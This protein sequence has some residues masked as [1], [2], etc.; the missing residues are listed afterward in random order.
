MI[1][2]NWNT[3]LSVSIVW[4]AVRLGPRPGSLTTL[5]RPACV[6]R[7]WPRWS[8]DRRKPRTLHSPPASDMAVTWRP[9]GGR[10][11]LSTPR[12]L[13]PPSSDKSH[14]WREGHHRADIGEGEAPTPVLCQLWWKQTAVVRRRLSW[15]Q[16]SPT[17]QHQLCITLCNCPVVQIFLVVMKYLYN[18]V[19]LITW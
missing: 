9:R 8:R 14:W 15:S 12:Q 1:Q 5:L 16:S 3:K 19:I 4:L 13:S 10:S 7:E 17:S 6:E 18:S 11:P 2:N